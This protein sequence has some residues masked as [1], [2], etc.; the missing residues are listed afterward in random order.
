MKAWLIT[1]EWTS[2]IPTEKIVAIESSRRS[3]S[4]IAD[5]MELFVLRSLYSAKEVAYYANRKREMVYKAQTPIGING[6]PH[7]ERILCGHDPWL[8]GRKVCDLKIEIDETS[9][10]EILTWREPDNYKWADDSKRSIV[11]ASE[12]DVR[13]W[14]RPNK[15]LAK[16][17]WA[18]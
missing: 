10:E 6:V 5:L 18:W 9:D 1:W 14:H 12:G 11:I 2:T 13:H 15:P 4:S 16:D 8:Y 7:G 3:T 17:V